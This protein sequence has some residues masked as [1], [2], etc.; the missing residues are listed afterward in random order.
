M[1]FKNNR[2]NFIN[3]LIKENIK[4][5]R[6]VLLSIHG[7]GSHFQPSSYTYE[8]DN[9]SKEILFANKNM[10]SYA[11]ELEGHGKSEGIRCYIRSFD[12]LVEDVKLLVII[13]KN[14]YP[15]LP[16]YLIGYSMGGAVCIHFMIKYKKLTQGLILFAP[17]CGIKESMK[18]S[19]PVQYILKLLSFIF[20]DKP[21]VPGSDKDFSKKCTSNQ[22]YIESKLNDQYGYSSNHRLAT[23]Y[24]CLNAC[25]FITSNYENFLFPVLIFHGDIDIVTD[26]KSSEQFYHNIESADKTFV[27]IKNGY[28]NLLIKSHENDKNPEFIMN[29]LFNWLDERIDK[30]IPIDYKLILNNNNNNNNNNNIFNTSIIII[31]F[32]LMLSSIV[33][34]FY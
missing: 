11:M 4:N 10:I 30:Y 9:E 13:I 34:F 5:P 24:S 1:Q 21:W 33:I 22:K 18:P 3:V 8:F 32:I 26:Y 12:N 28:H 20:P 17:M 2:G 15:K 31:S 6:G 16:I 7:I 27:S 14:K 25:D 29:T 23:A 19:Q